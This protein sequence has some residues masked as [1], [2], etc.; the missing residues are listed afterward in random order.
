[1]SYHVGLPIMKLSFNPG[2]TQKE[3]K[4]GKTGFVGPVMKEMFDERH[5]KDQ[6]IQHDLTNQNNWIIRER[7]IKQEIDE[8]TGEVL[9]IQELPNLTKDY[10]K[11]IKEMMQDQNTIRKA[12]GLKNLRKD[13]VPLITGIIKVPMII[14]SEPGFDSEKFYKDSTDVLDIL[15]KDKIR[16]GE[17]DAAVIHNDEY[18]DRDV[19]LRSP[20]CHYTFI[21]YVWEKD[22]VTGEQFKTLNAKKFCNTI[23]FNKINRNYPRMMRDRGWDVL[24][25]EMSED[26]ENKAEQKA[27]REQASGKDAILYKAEAE[28]EKSK[29]IDEIELKNKELESKEKELNDAKQEI[30]SKNHELE[31]KKN[32]LVSIQNEKFKLEET[33]KNLE[34]NIVNLNN[35]IQILNNDF[36]KFKNFYEEEKRKLKN[37]YAKL[38]E[39]YNKLA[40]YVNELI[41]SIRPLDRLKSVLYTL[42]DYT[43]NF[44]EAVKFIKDDFNLNLEEE[45]QLRDFTDFIE[46]RQDLEQSIDIIEALDNNDYS[47]NP[48]SLE[49]VLI[50]INQNRNNDPER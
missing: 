33:N 25:C 35:Q 24:D 22:P 37:D 49:D 2:R 10:I 26:I 45:N 48:M 8:E 1:M 18:I 27:K 46:N 15:M 11:E 34:N 3:K 50:D 44:I 41:E 23:F 38:V 31:T 12:H 43:D 14:A 40:T 30:N 47:N 20:H 13:C 28:R 21:P 6:D 19:E 36:S 4:A 39:K 29:L 42:R 9:S 32:E 5:G 16:C 7:Q 17:I